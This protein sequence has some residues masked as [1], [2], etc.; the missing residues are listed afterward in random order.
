MAL[1]EEIIGKTVT[2]IKTTD[3]FGAVKITDRA[4]YGCTKL[5]SIS[6]P[7]MVEEICGN[8]FTNCTSLQNIDLRTVKKIGNA[9]FSGCT[10]LATINTELLP[11]ICDIP[12]QAFTDTPW[13]KALPDRLNLLCDGKIAFYAKNVSAAEIPASVRTI[14]TGAFN[15]V[16]A[17]SITVPDTVV[18]IWGNAFGNSAT[19][20]V[21]I[22]A[23]VQIMGVGTMGNS[24]VTTWICRQPANMVLDIPKEAGDGKGLAYNKN[25]RSFTLYTDNEMLKAYNWSG[26]NVTATIKPLSEAPA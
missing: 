2:E 9:A 26:D 20:K 23:G 15:S 1:I 22:G 12:T 14:S 6:F 13:F 7:E 5:T 16:A 3:L 21:T 4:F 24:K 19:T 25:S 17:S 8:S 10:K 11:E 18:R